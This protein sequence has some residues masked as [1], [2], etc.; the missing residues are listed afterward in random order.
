MVE[1]LKVKAGGRSIKMPN[2][3]VRR[4]RVLPITKPADLF[5]LRY[6]LRGTT[7]VNTPSSAGR[8]LGA[9]GPL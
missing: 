8:A 5:E 3:T 4:D 2:A 7:V 6:R 1:A 9:V